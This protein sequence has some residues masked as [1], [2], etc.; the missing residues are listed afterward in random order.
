MAPEPRS[1]TTWSVSDLAQAQP[2]DRTLANLL[3]A[4]LDKHDICGRMAVFEYEATS[5]G[6]HATAAA[7]HRVAEQE[8]Q[9]FHELLASL[10]RHLNETQAL[11]RHDRQR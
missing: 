7:L 2:A 8:R 11:E 4:V 10:Y 5:E 1:R 9:C 3:R 6:H